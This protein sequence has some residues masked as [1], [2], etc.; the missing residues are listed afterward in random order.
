MG[1]GMRDGECPE[2]GEADMEGDRLG[3]DKK[4]DLYDSSPG[5]LDLLVPPEEEVMVVDELEVEREAME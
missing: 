4:V 1:D 3:G 5:D 2:E